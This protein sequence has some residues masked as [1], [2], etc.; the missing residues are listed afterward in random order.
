VL[1][2]VA[3]FFDRLDDVG[4]RGVLLVLLEAG[5]QFRLPA[6]AQFLQRRHV[7]VAVV[8]EGFQLRH[9]ARH[10]AAVLADRVAAHRRFVG[11]HPLLQE[12]DQLLFGLGFGHG[13]GLHA[14]DQARLAVGALVPVVHLVQRFVALVDGEH[15]TFGQMFSCVGDDDGHFDDAVGVRIEAGHFHVEPDQVHSLGRGGCSG[16]WVSLLVT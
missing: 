16:V 13:R 4:Q 6:A 11:R 1:A 3:Q 7:Q 12:G 8:E 5:R 9:A 10:E 14:V 2:V 15:G